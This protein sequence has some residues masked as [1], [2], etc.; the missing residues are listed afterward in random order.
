[1]ACEDRPK[2]CFECR[3]PECIC[4]EKASDGEI[5]FKFCGLQKEPNEN[6]LKEKH[7]KI[8]REYS[9]KYYRNRRRRQ[10]EQQI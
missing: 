3:Y 5:G 4:N 10:D 7:R 9:R 8:K 1:M 6:A 2:A